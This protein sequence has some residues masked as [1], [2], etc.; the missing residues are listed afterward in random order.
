M[1]TRKRF[2]AIAEEVDPPKPATPIGVK[3]VS[4]YAAETN[5]TIREMLGVSA[6]D[7]RLKQAK[8]QAL[9]ELAMQLGFV[10]RDET[11]TRLG[12]GAEDYIPTWYERAEADA[13]F[14]AR[15]LESMG[16]ITG[17]RRKKAAVQVPVY[18]INPPPAA[19]R[20]EQQADFPAIVDEEARQQATIDMLGSVVGFTPKTGE[21]VGQFRERVLA[22]ARNLIAKGKEDSIFFE[23]EEFRRVNVTRRL[24]YDGV[25]TETIY[26]G[27]SGSERIT[28]T[29][30]REGRIEQP[31]A[32]GYDGRVYRTK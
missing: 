26:M 6:L 22:R 12:G 27:G 30:R 7:L 17:P 20:A 31:T 19:Q 2:S 23:G 15:I 5:G 10:R 14:R 21:S 25:V 1:T 3:P 29:I 18:Q 9:D 11:S 4:K 8:G 13:D 32:F 16:A 28:I 24:D